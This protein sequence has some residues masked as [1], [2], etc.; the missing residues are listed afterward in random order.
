MRVYIHVHTQH[1]ERETEKESLSVWGRESLNQILF[2]FQEFLP[3]RV[4]DPVPTE[5]PTPAC[6]TDTLRLCPQALPQPRGER[7]SAAKA[8]GLPS[9]PASAREHQD[10]SVWVSNAR[11]L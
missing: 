11:V 9:G 6:G 10:G 7:E 4:W 5:H 1:T 8:P 2:L 3:C